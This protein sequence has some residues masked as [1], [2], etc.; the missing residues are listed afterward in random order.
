[1]KLG[2]VC[3]LGILL[4]SL[5][6]YFYSSQV[7][8]PGCGVPKGGAIGSPVLWLIHC[9]GITLPLTQPH[10]QLSGHCVGRSHMFALGSAWVVGLSDE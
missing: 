10:G 1:M 7:H 2:R 9:E 4:Y 3:V 6:Q 8:P 5:Y